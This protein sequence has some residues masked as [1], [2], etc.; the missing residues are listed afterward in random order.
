MGLLGLR[1]VGWIF[2]HPPREKGFFFSGPE[3]LFAAEQQLEAAQGVN[4]T[5]FV[6]VK[7]TL[8]AEKS[9]AVVEVRNS[10]I[11]IVSNGI[12]AVILFKAFQVSKQCMEMTAEGVL[13]VCPHLGHLGV[14]KT[15]T[16]LVEG[17]NATEVRAS[18]V[19]YQPQ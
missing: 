2:A 9:Q 11:V 1:K 8:D 15:F 7:V 18:T 13:E 14:N 4:D 6:T 12:I 16:A 10:S 17:K 19:N 3:I 5:P